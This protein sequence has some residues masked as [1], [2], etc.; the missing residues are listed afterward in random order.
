MSLAQEFHALP[1]PWEG[2]DAL[3]AEHS[4]VTGA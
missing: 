3:P 4:L 2:V 1:T